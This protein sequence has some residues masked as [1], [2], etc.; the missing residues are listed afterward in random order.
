MEP[1]RT[2]NGSF[3]SRLVAAVHGRTRRFPRT[4]SPGLHPP[5][6]RTL[7][8]DLFPSLFSVSALS[9]NEE[10]RTKNASSPGTENREL[11]T[12]FLAPNSFVPYTL[13]FKSK[14]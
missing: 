12:P 7:V 9:K 6:L 1:R 8:S 11:G 4:K 5:V 14:W 13:R 2:N 10:R 3:T